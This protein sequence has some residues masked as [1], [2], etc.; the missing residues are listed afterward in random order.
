MK[1]QRF[2]KAI[3][4]YLF[5]GGII[6]AGSFNSLAQVVE[7]YEDLGTL[8][9]LRGQVMDPNDGFMPGVDIQLKKAD[10]EEA[11][12][13]EE[14]WLEVDED[15]VFT[16]ENLQPG[17]YEIRFVATGFNPTVV[18]IK[19]DPNDYTATDQYILVRMSPGCSSGGSVELGD[20]VE[21][22]EK[23]QPVRF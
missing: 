11:N 22:E 2:V 17:E 8:R 10:S 20:K 21:E 13:E 16:D 6:L 5:V 19:I 9:V 3:F 4:V 1:G 15:G 18:K 23:P 7:T 14:V 12:S